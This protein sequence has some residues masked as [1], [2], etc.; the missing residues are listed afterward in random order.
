MSAGFQLLCESAPLATMLMAFVLVW[1]ARR[2]SSA[3]RSHLVVMAACILA[4]AAPLLITALPKWRVLPSFSSPRT[5]PDP[6]ARLSSSQPV[7]VGISQRKSYPLWF[8][9][10]GGVW[11]AGSACCLT[12][13]ALRQAGLRHLLAKGTSA[14]PPTLTLAMRL[15][16]RR[17]IRREVR[18]MVH[19]AAGSPFTCGLWNPCIVLPASHEKMSYADLRMVLDH[20][21]AHIQRLDALHGWILEAFLAMWWFHPLAWLTFRHAEVIKERACDDLVLLSGEDPRRYA[22]CLGEAVL[23]AHRHPSSLAMVSN[24]ARKAPQL[25]RMHAILDPTLDR[26]HLTSRETLSACAPLTLAAVVLSSLGFKAASELQPLPPALLASEPGARVPSLWSDALEPLARSVGIAQPPQRAE[27][28]EIPATGTQHHRHTASSPLRVGPSRAERPIHRFQAQTQQAT[29][30]S[31]RSD[32]RNH[33]LPELGAGSEHPEISTQSPPSFVGNQTSSPRI[34][35]IAGNAPITGSP[36]AAAPVS[37]GA[38]E[39]FAFGVA[40]HNGNSQ[41]YGYVALD[42]AGVL[43]YSGI[44]QPGS[45]GNPDAAAGGS[46]VADSG[47]IANDRDLSTS[48]IQSPAPDTGSASLGQATSSADPAGSH[49]WLTPED[50]GIR[51]L[52]AAIEHSSDGGHLSV[53]FEVPEQTAK[54]WT[55]EASAD[56]Q[57]WTDSKDVISHEFSSGTSPGFLLLRASLLEPVPSAHHTQLRL[58]GKW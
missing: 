53:S 33:A 14:P 55:A 12:A 37:V 13:C 52:Q 58:R 38:A 21:M 57:S 36:I 54:L 43:V 22:A 4:L 3:T 31:T 10:A 46:L 30:R 41:A 17:G 20:E 5:A 11:L 1:L 23:R 27:H 44:H 15:K 29:R 26:S 34:S 47:V 18:L 45:A 28:Q 48:A 32:K 2:R 19:H 39:S 6:V 40:G 9:L 25:A 24:F 8:R 7:G 16:S 35:P 51:N 42:D 56:A 49:E 50:M